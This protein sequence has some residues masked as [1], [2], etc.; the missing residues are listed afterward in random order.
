VAVVDMVAGARGMLLLLVHKACPL[1]GHYSLPAPGSQH[2]PDL[3]PHPWERRM[4]DDDVVRAS[5]T[6]HAYLPRW[7]ATSFG[8]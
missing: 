2:F 1:R 4:E 7:L 8:W 3:P 5:V 6:A